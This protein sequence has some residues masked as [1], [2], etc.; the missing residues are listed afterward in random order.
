MLKFY[1]NGII[2]FR[3][4]GLEDASKNQCNK[5]N[6]FQESEFENFWS[7]INVLLI[8]GAIAFGIL[9]LE[10]IWKFIVKKRF[11]EIKNKIPFHM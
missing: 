8:G 3:L 10:I 6:K 5:E 11:R 9:S 7:I 4:R 2:E 1:E